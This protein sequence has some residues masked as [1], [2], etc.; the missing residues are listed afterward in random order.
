MLSLRVADAMEGT[1]TGLEVWVKQLREA[2][3]DTAD[4][5]GMHMLRL[6]QT[7]SRQWSSRVSSQGLLLY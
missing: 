5:L 3:Y 6:G 4:A 7:T 1:N 2:A